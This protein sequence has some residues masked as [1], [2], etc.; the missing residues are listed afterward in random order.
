MRSSFSGYLIAKQGISAA[1]AGLDI[2]GQNISNVNTT[3]Y[4][5]QR[6]DTV[7]VGSLTGNYTYSSTVSDYI[8]NGVSVSGYSQYRDVYLDTRYRQK[9]AQYG[10]A[11]AQQSGLNELG[12]VF[13]DATTDGLN[14][15][16][17]D[18]VTQLQTLSSN[19]T[20]TVTEGIVRTSAV[21]LA[22][23]LNDFAGQV[24]SAKEQLKD[25]VRTGA[26][27]DINNYLS[28]I[29][30]LNQAI[31]SA[32]ISGDPAL[33]LNDERNVL[34]DEL[35]SYMDIQVNTYQVDVGSGVSVDQ[36]SVSLKTSNGD[37]FQLVNDDQYASFDVIEEDG[38]IGIQLLDF[39]GDAVSYSTNGSVSVENGDVSDVLTTGGLHGYLT[40]IN[41]E[42]EF[43]DPPTTEKGIPYYEKALDLLA[44]KLADT[45]NS[46]NSTD[47]EDKP[48][49][50][51]SDGSGVI[52]ASNITVSQDWVNS[53]ST[54]ITATKLTSGE[55]VDNSS[56]NSNILAMISAFETSYDFNADSGTTVFSGTFNNYTTNLSTVL[57][58]QISN[59]STS[60]SSAETTL[61]E[62]SEQ[63]MSVSG[64]ST[65][66]EVINMIMYNQALAASSRFMTT[67]DEALDMII[68]QMGLVG[69]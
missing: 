41:S 8:G 35:S 24:S 13:D 30:Q 69:R 66:E 49:F 38:G 61:N 2:T 59:V 26:V 21:S 34:L 28:N 47:T 15:Q 11:V 36:L 25:T 27:A 31:K 68:N 56:D 4:T 29:A 65:D 39:D 17:S 55:G 60:L 50:E 51:A 12:Y 52:T 42:G 5:R 10:D 40:V 53:T 18:F 1:R 3:G 32:N 44:S 45:L 22:Q 23:M 33:E 48:L 43:G 7:A 9:N 20:D 16:L 14:E 46:L 57:G 54:Y 67:M 58:T 19:P 64:V 6:V 37:T 63:R 62:I